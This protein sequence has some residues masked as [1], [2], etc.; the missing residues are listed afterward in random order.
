MNEECK[1]L[2]THECPLGTTPNNFYVIVPI[3]LFLNRFVLSLG[4]YPIGL[5]YKEAQ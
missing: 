2:L 4:N 3:F 1:L 5:F